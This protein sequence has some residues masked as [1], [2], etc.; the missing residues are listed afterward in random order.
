MHSPWYDGNDAEDEESRNMFDVGFVRS[1]NRVSQSS[2][3]NISI[4][5]NVKGI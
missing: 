1:S 2:T 3:L 4:V 5:I